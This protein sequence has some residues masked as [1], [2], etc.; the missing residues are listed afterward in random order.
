MGTLIAERQVNIVVADDHPIF[1]DGL[2]R[3]L[4]IEDGVR[5]IGE[6]ED[7]IEAV[8]VTRLLHPDI[9]LLDLNMPK[10]NGMEVL[11]EFANSPT[12]VRIIVLTAMIEKKQIIEALQ[13]G[14]RG[15]VLKDS[16]TRILM[17]AIQ[18][19]GEGNYWVAREK[20]TNLVDY[21]KKFVKSN[22][23]YKRFGLT[24]REIDIISAVVVGI[25]NR[26]IG[27][28]FKIAENT[29]KHHL[30]S[31]FDKTG[32]YNRLELAMFA[33]NNGIPLKEIS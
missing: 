4:E 7:G 31:I 11:H 17:E 29:V 5:V 2:K 24:E 14:A 18:S 33:V 9:L 26:E 3:L 23:Q 16:A 8:K 22:N 27:A 15:I 28:H 13:Y 6:A 12:P 30:S 32:V 19:V 1:R 10:S 21:L 20:V 25:T